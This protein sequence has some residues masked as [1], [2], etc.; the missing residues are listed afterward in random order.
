MTVVDVAFVDVAESS[1]ADDEELVE[2]VGGGSD[3]GDGEVTAKLRWNSSSL[4]PI[5]NIRTLLSQLVG[6]VNIEQSV[7]SIVNIGIKLTEME[8]QHVGEA[9]I[10]KENPSEVRVL[11]CSL[12]H[13]HVAFSSVDL[14]RCCVIGNLGE[15][16][17]HLLLNIRRLLI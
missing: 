13:T 10:N 9:R 1:D 12:I 7:R 4:S 3:F 6:Y 11:V 8:S 16:E 15:V 17:F 14:I 2:V 5:K